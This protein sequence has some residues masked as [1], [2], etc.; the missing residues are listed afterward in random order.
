VAL[1]VVASITVE[2]AASWAVTARGGQ[3][4]AVLQPWDHALD[5]LVPVG[6]AYTV[7]AD[8]GQ[9][10]KSTSASVICCWDP[11]YSITRGGRP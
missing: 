8:A 5:N 3:A 10:R 1:F 11:A 6:Y 7:P 2:R 9:R 4:A